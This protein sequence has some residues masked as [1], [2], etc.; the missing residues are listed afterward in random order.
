MTIITQ[1]TNPIY[2]N[3]YRKKPHMS[4]QQK[5]KQMCIAKDN[6]TILQRIVDKLFFGL[7]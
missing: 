1:I 2:D 4:I 6:M 5:I 3:V 7:F